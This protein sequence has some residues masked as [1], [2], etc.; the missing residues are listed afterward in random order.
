MRD[1]CLSEL[2]TRSVYLHDSSLCK[3]VVNH[4]LIATELAPNTSGLISVKSVFCAD[5]PAPTDKLK[6]PS[7]L[8][9][10]KQLDSVP[11]AM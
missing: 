5:L 9:G 8:V 1:K 7:M 6:F 3:E 2:S 11:E 4:G 10:E